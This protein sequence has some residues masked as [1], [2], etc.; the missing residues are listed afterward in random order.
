LVTVMLSKKI[1]ALDSW[2]LRRIL[3]VL[4]SHSCQTLSAAAVCPSLDTCT[5][6][7]P[8]KTI[9]VLCKPALWVLLMIGDGGLALWP[10][11]KILAE[12][13]RGSPATNEPRTGDVEATCSGQIDMAQR[14]L[15][16]TATSSLRQ[17]PEEGEIGGQI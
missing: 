2:C 10:S 15:M 12:N 14:K 9:T 17:A 8:H 7:T 4:G 6:P 11:Q 3:N 1:D 16:T 13:S 5:T